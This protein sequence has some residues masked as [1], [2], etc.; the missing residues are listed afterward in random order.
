[1]QYSSSIVYP[2]QVIA[3]GEDELEE[4]CLEYID[5]YPE[6][7]LGSEAFKKL[8]KSTLQKIVKRDSLQEGELNVYKACIQWAESECIRSEMEVFNSIYFFNMI[9]I[10]FWWTRID[11]VSHSYSCFR[12]RVLN[13]Y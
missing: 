9:C 3:V 5:E 10:I 8:K 7:V 6:E 4:K 1:M 11:L 2:N 13:Y 12:L